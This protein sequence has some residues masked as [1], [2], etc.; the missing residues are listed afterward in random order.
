MKSKLSKIILTLQ[1]VLFLFILISLF[2]PLIDFGIDIL[3]ISMLIIPI[4]TIISG[5]FLGIDFFHHKERN[6]IMLFALIIGLLLFGLWIIG[7]IRILTFGGGI[8]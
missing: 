1:L 4:F 3:L 6:K 2:T 5:I 7:I 8:V